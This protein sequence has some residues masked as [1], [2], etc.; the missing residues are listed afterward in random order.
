MGRVVRRARTHAVRANP[1]VLASA[2]AS[3]DC[4]VESEANAGGH[5]P[6]GRRGGAPT[7]AKT[8][9]DAT[10]TRAGPFDDAAR[11]VPDNASGAMRFCL[12]TEA[13][14]APDASSFGGSAV[15]RHEVVDLATDRLERQ[16][17]LDEYGVQ[18]ISLP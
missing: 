4:N 2:R 3:L 5:G 8:T 14:S 18:W 13:P 9:R 15:S 11:S 7:P 10:L 17:S 1:R 16:I 6:K 12:S